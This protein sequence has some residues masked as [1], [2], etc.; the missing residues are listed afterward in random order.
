[1]KN[2]NEIHI[3]NLDEDEFF[4]KKKEELELGEFEDEL[5]DKLKNIKLE[6][7]NLKNKKNINENK[8]LSDKIIE[9]FFFFFHNDNY[10]FLIFAELFRKKNSSKEIEKIF[11]SCGIKKEFASCLIKSTPF[12]NFCKDINKIDTN[13]SQKFV[14]MISYK[15][16]F[17]GIITLFLLFIS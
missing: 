2:Q 13:S 10:S 8:N 16:L 15:N 7:E 14:N 11:A 5:M 17:K 9:E 3:C 12:V 4:P 1:M 6:Y